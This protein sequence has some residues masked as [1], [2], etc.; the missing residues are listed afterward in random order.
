MAV[1]VSELIQVLNQEAELFSS[2]LD[3]LDRQRDMLV[4]NDIDGLNAVTAEQREK[5]AFS[6]ILD[7]RRRNLIEEV[8]RQNEIE[9]DLTVTRLL[10]SVTA[11]QGAQLNLMRD[12]I[13]ELN[14]KIEEGRQRNSFLIE[15][16]RHLVSETLRMINRMGNSS[17]KGAEYGDKGAIHTRTSAD[18]RRLSLTLD[19]RV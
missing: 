13:L 7:V 14:D 6:R 8:A 12:T 3:L 9:G 18:A 4:T 1:N 17:Q 5:L 11:E 10:E 2:F 19:R 15:K 16:S